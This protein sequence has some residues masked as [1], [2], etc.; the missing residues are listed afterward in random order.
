[1]FN[2]A[3]SD[4]AKRVYYQTYDVTSYLKEGNN[5]LG[6]ILGNGWYNLV[7]PH[8]LRFY[9]ADYINTPRLLF[10]LDVLY[11]DGTRET[12]AS[13]ETWSFSTD[14]PIRFNNIYSGETYD[15]NKQIDGWDRNGY[16]DTKWKQAVQVEAPTGNLV[17][18]QL[19]PVRTVEFVKATKI[20]PIEDGYSIDLE[21]EITGWCRF[22]VRGEKGDKITVKYPGEESHTLG[23][24]QSYE[25]ILKGEGTE[26]LEAKFSYNG[27]R[28][29][30]IYGL[31]YKPELDD[32]QGVI[33]VTDFPEAGVFQCSNDTLNEMSSI[34]EHTLKNYVVHLPNDP[35]REKSGWTQDVQA[36]FDIFSYTSECMSMFQKWQRDFLDKIF[37][38][39]YV[40]PVVP[41]RYYGIGINGPWW[42]GNIVL[43]PWKIYQFYGDK[44]VLEESYS[45]MKKYVG[46]LMSIDSSYVLNWGLGDWLEAGR[47][48]TSPGPVKTPV[49]LTSTVGYYN[50]VM[51]V[52]KTAE[53]LNFTDDAEDFLNITEKIKNAYNQKF[54]DATT[55]EYGTYS[56]ASQLMSLYF[57]LVPE[58]KRELVLDKLIKKIN[59]ASNHIST[60]FIATPYIL[61]GLSDL[62]QGD[63]AYKLATQTTY[64]GWYDM[65]YN[66]GKK[67]FKED[68]GLVGK[69]QMPILAGGFGYWLYHSL[70]G[71]RP[72][73]ELP[74][75]ERIII[76]PDFVDE[77]SWVEGS[78]QSAYGKIES[79]WERDGDQYTLNVEIPA[80]TT[81]RIFLPTAQTGSI[82]ESGDQIKEAKGIRSVALS[83]GNTMIETGSGQYSF[84]FTKE[85]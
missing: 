69:V 40:P 51:I 5:T 29:V 58:G 15:F 32:V 72:D 76:R 79:G 75:F 82:L 7:V 9:A 3:Y 49:P 30:E 23:R 21:K 35:V 1:L 48:G 59:S 16:D 83:D 74:G 20:T 62:G 14:G 6:V 19:H 71:I 11:T 47:G 57:D 63:L 26:T 34:L 8:L 46:Y 66:H 56:Q 10:Q 45:S 65:V 61:T 55:G 70:L 33:V 28:V 54:F 77:L 44:R 68:W 2:P 81:A 50:L 41:G 13:D 78:Y 27:I 42:G 25:Y 24:Y 38:D 80:N 39:G 85:K 17:P 18:Q 36:T 12:I 64:P 67:I 60:G 53:I 73:P 37:D 43:Q 4:Y 31:G 52:A 22:F 84:S